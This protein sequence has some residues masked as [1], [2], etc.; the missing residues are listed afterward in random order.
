M[1]GSES[2]GRGSGRRLRIQRGLLGRALLRLDGLA[3]PRDV[4]LHAREQLTVTAGGREGQTLAVDAQCL[5]E[6]AAL[7]VG[8]WRARRG[9][10]PSAAWPR[11]RG[12]LPAPPRPGHR[13]RA[14]PAPRR[15]GRPAPPPTSTDGGVA[16]GG[17]IAGELSSRAGF[18]YARELGR[19]RDRNGGCVEVQ[20]EPLAS[21]GTRPTA[22]GSGRSRDRRTPRPAR[23][24]AGCRAP[25]P[26]HLAACAAR[27]SRGRCSGRGLVSPDAS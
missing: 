4:A 8:R 9:R 17:L 3:Q 7:L 18:A 15:A 1:S 12:V 13:T 23:T 11:A 24:A 16:S 20:V 14:R 21:E 27:R 5:V 6:L 10:H 22:R 25:C 2:P 19:R 26:L